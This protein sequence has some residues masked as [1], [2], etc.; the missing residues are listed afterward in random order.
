MCGIT[1]NG[2]GPKCFKR[3]TRRDTGI[4]V[5]NIQKAPIVRSDFGTIRPAYD[6]RPNGLLNKASRR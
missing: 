5:P 6:G 1:A 3:L 4:R 2:M